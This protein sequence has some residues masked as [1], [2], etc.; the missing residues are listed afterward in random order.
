M[1]K[2][3]IGTLYLGNIMTTYLAWFIIKTNVGLFKK[4]NLYNAKQMNI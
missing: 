3:Y 2:N 4:C 1:K